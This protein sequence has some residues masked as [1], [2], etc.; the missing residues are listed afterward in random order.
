MTTLLLSTKFHIP[1]VRAYLVKRDRLN[2]Q[3]NQGLCC[4][5]ILISA[6][7]GFGKTT[8]LSVWLRQARI[9]VSWLS[10]DEGDNDPHDFGLTS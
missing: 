2:E 5:L 6:P 3:L 7:A 10:L 4:K 8:V 1:S 9:P